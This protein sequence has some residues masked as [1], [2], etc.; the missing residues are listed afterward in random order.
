MPVD[1]HLNNWVITRSL[2]TIPA[3]PLWLYQAQ[4]GN[5]GFEVEDHYVGIVLFATQNEVCPHCQQFP[6]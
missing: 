6:Q 5:C 4:C 1:D 2:F 3:T